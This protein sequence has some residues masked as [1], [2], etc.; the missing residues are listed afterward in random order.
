[1]CPDETL[2]FEC[3]IEGGGITVWEGTLLTCP[4]SD[5]IEIS[6]NS[7]EP[8]ERS[9]SY[10]C[11][12][13]AINATVW[14]RLEGENNYYSRLSVSRVLLPNLSGSTVKCTYDNG[15]H[16]IDVGTWTVIGMVV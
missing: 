6:H 3:T 9:L 16:E 4:P 5:S 8:V 12:D 15:S 2:E 13:Q 7:F 11:H 10:T 14:Y 1:M